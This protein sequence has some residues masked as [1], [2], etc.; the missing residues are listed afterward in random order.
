MSETQNSIPK[1]TQKDINPFLKI[2]QESGFS[3]E[4]QRTFDFLVAQKIF[5]PPDPG[6]E[7]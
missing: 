1:Q 6:P 4:E 2:A 7:E 5:D 3:E